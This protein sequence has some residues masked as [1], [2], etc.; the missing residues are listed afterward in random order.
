MASSD[1]MY[2]AIVDG[3][4]LADRLRPAHTHWTR[5]RGLLGTPRLEP[6]EG[7]W[8][9]PSNQVHMFGMRYA[10]DVVF[11]DDA[12]RVLRLIHALQPNRISPRVKDATSVLELP[13]GTLARAGLEEGGTVD[14]SVEAGPRGPRIRFDVVG[15]LVCNL[16]LA[17]LYGFFAAA[18]LSKA[19]ATGQWATTMPLVAQEAFLVVLVL[20]RRRSLATSGRPL[21]WVVAAAGTFLPLFMRPGDV[22]GPLRWLG[23]PL[24]CVGVM[25]AFLAFASL[26]RSFGLVAANR[27]I[28][29][30]G[31][32]RLVRHPA[33]AGHLL[34]YAGYVLCY[35]TPRNALIAI[36]TLLALNARV[37]VEERFLQR[38]PSYRE[39][40]RGTRWRLVPY[41][42]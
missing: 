29:T 10:I 12:G 33:Y 24:Q 3:V 23:Q 28:K 25:A 38:D 13:A 19:M 39:Y 7:L 21:D 1:A 11:L 27:G 30:S 40:L 15:M 26:R 6:G 9:K 42:Y 17:L 36:T 35:P 2:R 34:G 32:Y 8:I 37:I 16:A 18:H 14:I 31:L 20:A 4:V 41:L 22:P 5:L